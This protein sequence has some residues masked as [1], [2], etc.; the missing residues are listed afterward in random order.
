[1]PVRHPAVM[2]RVKTTEAPQQLGSHTAMW[3]WDEVMARLYRDG[4]GSVDWCADAAEAVAAATGSVVPVEPG[5]VLC[6]NVQVGDG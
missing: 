1:M 4:K 6:I 3:C 5:P 2:L